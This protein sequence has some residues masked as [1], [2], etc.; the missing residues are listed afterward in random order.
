MATGTYLWNLEH[1]WDGRWILMNTFKSKRAAEDYA[2]TSRA[3]QNNGYQIKR[4][5]VRRR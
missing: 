5:H 4:V 3:C 1:R 2:K